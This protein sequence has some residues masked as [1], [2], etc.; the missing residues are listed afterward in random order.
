MINGYVNEDGIDLYDEKSPGA[1]GGQYLGTIENFGDEKE[2]RNLVELLN[3]S[4][5]R[6]EN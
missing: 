1:I 3:I 5:S 2:R 6:K 4:P